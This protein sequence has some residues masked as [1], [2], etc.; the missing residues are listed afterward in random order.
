M[1]MLIGNML[2][3]GKHSTDHVELNLNHDCNEIWRWR[4]IC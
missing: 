4:E 3:P 2:A 1:A